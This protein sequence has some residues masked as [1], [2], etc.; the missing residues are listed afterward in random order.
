MET[1]VTLKGFDSLEKKLVKILNTDFKPEL[2]FYSALI[3]SNAKLIAP[4]DPSRPPKDMSQ[5][6]SGML[7]RSI[8]REIFDLKAI[9][10]TNIEYAQYLE[11]GT[12]YMKARPFLIPSFLDQRKKFKNAI[13]LKL[14]ESVKK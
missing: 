3:Q 1:K 5:K 6:V 4:R 2:T 8:K 13:K 11:F 7:R 10:F 14:K 9:I 12:R